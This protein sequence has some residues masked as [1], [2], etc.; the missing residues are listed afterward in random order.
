M[1]LKTVFAV[2][3]LSA[4]IAGAESSPPPPS[5]AAILEQVIARMPRERLILSGSL[6]V[7][8]WRGTVLRSLTFEMDADWSGDPTIVGCTL[9]DAFGTDLERLS[10]TRKPRV[11]PSFAFA[12]GNPLTPAPLPDL[13]API[14]DSDLSW[15]DLVL[16]FIWWTDGRITGTDVVKDRPCH[17][18]EVFPSSSDLPDGTQQNGGYAGARLWIEQDLS[19]LLRAEGLDAKGETIRRLWVKSFKKIND[20]WMIKDLEIQGIP[21][22]HRTRLRVEEVSVRP[23]DGA[24]FDAPGPSAAESR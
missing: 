24:E 20:R 22:P 17:V 11:P 9:R 4:T 10:V 2:V 15:A 3:L 21:S 14:Y 19:I 8:T 23:R 13:F 5:A 1:N 18:L 7:R 16:T 12:R 6:T